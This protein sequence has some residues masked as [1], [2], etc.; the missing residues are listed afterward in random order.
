MHHTHEEDP[1]LCT[2]FQ[3]HTIILCFQQADHTSEHL[4][5]NTKVDLHIKLV[6]NIVTLA[7]R[8]I[9]YLLLQEP[10]VI[11]REWISR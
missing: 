8:P 9:G 2:S 5:T 4:Y 10:T 6:M 7:Y 11:K 3:F 1:V